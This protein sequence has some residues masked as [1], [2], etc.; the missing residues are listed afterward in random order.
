MCF[1]PT[2]LIEVTNTN[3]QTLEEDY[4]TIVLDPIVYLIFN[5]DTKRNIISITNQAI[6]LVG[7]LQ[8]NAIKPII[9]SVARAGLY[10]QETLY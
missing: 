8:T 6:G 4:F 5:P 9:G 10:F 3:V 1:R 7:I 2:V